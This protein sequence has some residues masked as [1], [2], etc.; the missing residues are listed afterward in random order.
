MG[1]RAGNVVSRGAGGLQTR[2]GDCLIFLVSS[3]GRK[4]VQVASEKSLKKY[5]AAESRSCFFLFFF[6]LIS[7]FSASI[8]FFKLFLFFE[9]FDPR[10][11]SH[12]RAVERHR[13]LPFP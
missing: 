2:T 6:F 5:F 7:F 11:V 8:L 9:R 1:E 10:N 4:S 13:A 12:R 3:A